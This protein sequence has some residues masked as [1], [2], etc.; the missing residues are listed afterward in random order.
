MNA[1][2]SMSNSAADFA[3]CFTF[4]GAGLLLPRC[5]RIGPVPFDLLGGYEY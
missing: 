1:S 5:V 4:F 2:S 3:V